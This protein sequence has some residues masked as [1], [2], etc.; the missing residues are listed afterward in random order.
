MTRLHTRLSDDSLI[1]I[2]LFIVLAALACITPAQNDTFWHLRSG[3]QMWQTRAFLLTEPF[4]HTAYGTALHNH[5]WLSQL[6]FFA[7]YS[8]GGPFLLTLVA[9]ACAVGATAGSWRLMKGPWELRIGLLAWLV[10]VTAPG[11]A[12]LA[13][14]EARRLAAGHPRRDRLLPRFRLLRALATCFT[15]C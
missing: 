14:T 8:L 6:V 7:V 11:D 9:G 4:S 1:P 5:W 12:T 3:Q 2:L 13:R 10:V 15:R